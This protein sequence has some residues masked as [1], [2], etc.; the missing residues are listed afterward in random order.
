MYV[1]CTHCGYDNSP[2]YRF[3]GMCGA[4]LARPAAA[5]PTPA[6]EQ[7]RATSAGNGPAESVHGPSFLGLAEDPKVEFHYL[8]EDEQPRSKVGLVVF[9]IIMLGAGGYLAYQWK[10]GGFPFNHSFAANN[11]GSQTSA[12]PSEVAPAESQDQQT[13]IDKP[14][15]G[16]GD[17][18]P[19]QPEQ[20]SQNQNPTNQ[21]S[22]NQAA[23]K[24]SETDI[25]SANAAQQNQNA[26]ANPAPSA[27]TPASSAQ[28]QGESQ[29]PAA[30]APA[31]TEEAKAT[32]PS[33]V[34]EASRT[35]REPVR[36]PKPTPSR[37]AAVASTS[38]DA[39]LESTGERYLYGNGVPQNCPRAETSLRTAAL[40][41]NSK[42]Q[43]VLGTMYATGHCVGRDLPTAY[44]WFARA[45]H[46]EPQNSRIS[47]D[48]QVL[49]RQMTPQEKQLAMA[50][51]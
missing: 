15:T 9:L 48:L 41:G 43:T 50:G 16:A 28:A 37:T 23:G 51:Q 4:A 42:A 26:A 40:H 49:W 1:K 12:S 2:E 46:Q 31:P 27:N 45:L 35:A 17:V 34:A 38:P 11:S 29:K 47:T 44:R 33:G 8:Y 19:T 6:K 39:D 20:N 5:E 14:M 10:N 32:P 13:H 24:P 36:T 7:P 21:S 18:L 22:Q 25:P 30:K 3:C